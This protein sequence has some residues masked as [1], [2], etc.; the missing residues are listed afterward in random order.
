[1]RETLDSVQRVGTIM[2]VGGLIFIF[3]TI[4]CTV[5]LDGEKQKLANPAEKK[6]VS[7]GY[8]IIPRIENEI[9]VGSD[10]FDKTT[11]KKCE[12]WK[13]FRGECT[14]GN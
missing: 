14:L 12:V 9:P 11:G 1:M 2:C 7:D 4:G 13:Y 3:S 6:C 8:K 10:C 5:N